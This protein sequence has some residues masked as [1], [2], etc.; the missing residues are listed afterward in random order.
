M[1]KR[2]T[3]QQFTINLTKFDNEIRKAVIDGWNQATV[4]AVNK[5]KVYAPLEI[6]TLQGSGQA[7]RAKITPR[8]ITSAFGFFVIGKTVKKGDKT[9]KISYPY[10]KDLE[11][12]ERPS[13]KKLNISKEFNKK[14]QS[15][16]SERGAKES[17]SIFLR[18]TN[19][20]IS[21]AYDRI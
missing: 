8:G 10:P 14:A 11:N 16:Y 12:G 18:V 20:A 2:E 6:G 13:G 1:A 9:Y 7:I 17:E 15:H 19:K 3:I 5:A 21:K 4:V